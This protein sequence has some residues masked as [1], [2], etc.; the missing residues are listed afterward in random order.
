LLKNSRQPTTMAQAFRSCR[1][2]KG[3]ASQVAEKLASTHYNGAAF[4]SC[5][6]GKGTA[7]AV[8]SRPGKLRA[9]APEGRSD[10]AP[11]E[12]SSYRAASLQGA[13]HNAPFVVWDQTNGP[14]F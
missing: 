9:L 8:P 11:A 12:I 3:T 5:R 10:S 1:I 4:R 14:A 6:V 13:P 2:G 7:S